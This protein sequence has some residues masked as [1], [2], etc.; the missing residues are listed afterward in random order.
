MALW[1]FSLLLSPEYNRPF[2]SNVPENKTGNKKYEN[3]S[4]KP[5]ETCI[6]AV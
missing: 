4:S 1:L 6:A 5:V 2:V 3:Q